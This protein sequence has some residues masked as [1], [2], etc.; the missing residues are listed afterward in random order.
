MP[1]HE[2]LTSLELGT[3]IARGHEPGRTYGRTAWEDRVALV[4]EAA[5][6]PDAEPKR[7]IAGRARDADRPPDARADAAILLACACR[8]TDNHASIGQLPSLSP[9]CMRANA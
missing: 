2:I 9:K 7:V 6:R 4:P 1:Q 3:E 5:Q 8:L